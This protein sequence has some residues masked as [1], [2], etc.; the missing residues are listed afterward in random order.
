MTVLPRRIGGPESGLAAGQFWTDLG[1]FSNG[2][3][4][5]AHMHFSCSA[6]VFIPNK[7]PRLLSGTLPPSIAI[8]LVDLK[9]ISV[10]DHGQIRQMSKV[11]WLACGKI[12]LLWKLHF[13]RYSSRATDV[14]YIGLTGL[15]R[16]ESAG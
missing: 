3:E 9:D 8:A 6:Y 12:G 7:P 5:R 16:P 2:S 13:S 11:R 15:T 14:I 1:V 10:E 4:I